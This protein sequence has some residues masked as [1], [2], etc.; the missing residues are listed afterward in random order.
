MFFNLFLII[1]T[2]LTRFV[3]IRWGNGF[4]FH[5][6]E[7]N[8]ITA[9]SNFSSTNLNP[10]FFAYGQFPLYLSYFTFAQ[11]PYG[12]R[13][14]AAIFSC[15]TIL[16]FYF[17]SKKIFQKKYW[18]FLLLLIFNPGLIQ[19]AH[20]GTTESLL[21]FVF[22][23]NMYIALLLAKKN[24]FKYLFF[25]AL[26]SGIGIA[27]KITAVIFIL[28]LIFTIYKNLRFTIYYLILTLIFS[29]LFSPYSIIAYNEFLK[30][31]SYETSVATGK[32]IVFYTRQ[33]LD[34]IPYYFQ[35]S[36]I[37]PYTSGIV[38]FILSIFGLF[39]LNKKFF[40]F[41]L[42]ALIYFLYTGQLF[43]K[44]TRFMSPVFFVFPFLATLFL[45]KINHKIFRNILILL[46]ILPA[47]TFIRIYTQEDTRIHASRYFN[48]QKPST[49]FSESGNVINIPISS[50]GHKIEN[51]NFYDLDQEGDG[52]LY[53]HIQKSDYILIPS[54][55]VFKNQNNDR[56]PLSKKY[57]S[58]LFSGELGFVLDKKIEIKSSLFLNSENAEETWSVFDH[59]IVRIYKR[60]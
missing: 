5:P 57:Y 37:F 18:I 24:K 34:T 1:S 4:F 21:I 35:F 27:T 50:N 55:R 17:I 47:L 45:I 15:L 54:R 44:W 31:M 53:K 39:K 40:L 13:I 49:I 7:N 52:L 28:P 59:P 8:M 6:D 42:P 36:K 14:W 38:V 2:V 9:I 22:T 46:S 26:I 25:A 41:L 60:K 43:V 12:L 29:C 11:N 20:F 58:K 10:N 19:L 16:F 48:Y 3:G 30:S 32:I 51:F 23:V 33:F 56:F